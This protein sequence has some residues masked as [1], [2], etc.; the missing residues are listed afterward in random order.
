MKK[1][2]IGKVYEEQGDKFAKF[3]EDSFSW[4][5]LEKPTFDRHL[6]SFYNSSTI[7]L[8]AGCGSGR[9]SGH[10]ISNGILEEN[11]TGVDLDKNLLNKT[12][13]KFPKIKLI[14]SD[15]SEAPIPE[16]TYD[17]IVSSMV[18]LYL[19]AEKLKKA[20]Q[21]F[22]RALKKGGTLF[23]LTTHPLRTSSNLKTSYQK[24]GWR[25]IVAPWGKTIPIFHR[26]MS[27]FVNETI[28]AGFTLELI[29]E[30]RFL[31]SAKSANPTE[32]ERYHQSHGA[33]RLIVKA[34]K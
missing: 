9:I 14:H 5:Y 22:Y 23:Y 26:S 7:V 33:P 31:P 13:Q 15:I 10:L 11:I 34:R 3:A 20:F 29:D 25:E 28:S 24:A 6:K 17:L 4:K 21:N 32:Y 1:I 16:N 18:L 2:N 30:P 19:D 27:D 8:D 12:H